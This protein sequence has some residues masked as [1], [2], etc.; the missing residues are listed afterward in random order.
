ME[1]RRPPKPINITSLCKI[2]PLHTNNF[3]VSWSVEP[4]T[5]LDDPE[6][7]IFKFPL[8]EVQNNLAIYGD[9][10]LLSFLVHIYFLSEVKKCYLII[11][12]SLKNYFT[13]VCSFFKGRGYTVS[14]YYV[15]KLTSNDLLKRLKNKGLRNSD[16]TRAVIKDKLNDKD[17]EIATTSCKV[18]LACPLGKYGYL[19]NRKL[20]SEK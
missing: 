15:D 4:G 5:I 8:Q 18:S 12:S 7:S 9:W 6:D 13:T 17:S 1:P 16:Y 20:N 14:V 3:N 11:L 10:F 2:S 19:I